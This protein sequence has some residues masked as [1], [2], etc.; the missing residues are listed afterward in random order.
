MKKKRNF[1]SIRWQILI[2]LVIATATPFFY[3]SI[4]FLHSSNQVSLLEE[5]RDKHYP[6]QANMERA[7]FT[8]KIIHS[9]M[10]DAVTTGEQE[11]LV[12]AKLLN[13]QFIEILN[14]TTYIDPNKKDSIHKIKQK[15]LTYFSNNYSLA[16]SLIN[17][18]INSVSDYLEV[19]A[20]NAKQYL[21]I[22][23]MLEDFNS[24]EMKKFSNAVDRVTDRANTIVNLGAPIG[25]IIISIIFFLGYQSVYR[26]I[27][28]INH[29]VHILCSIAKNENDMSVRIDIDGRDEMAEL[30][31]WFN[32]FMAKQEKDTI[33]ST[34]KIRQLAYMDTLT[35]LPNRRLFN[36]R[37][38]GEVEYCRRNHLSMAVMFLD[39]DNF[40]N[41][42]DQ[43][44]H[45][46]GDQLVCE[47]ARR[48]IDIVRKYDV[49]GRATDDTNKNY[50]LVSRMGGDEFNI[51]LARIVDKQSVAN[52]AGRILKE[53]SS[54]IEIQDHT[55]ET[56][57]SI[58]TA[59]YP[60]DALIA[61]ELIINADLAMYEAKR[62]GKN[63]HYFFHPTMKENT[64]Y[65]NDI[66]TSLKKVLKENGNNELF[67]HFQ[68]K[69][70]INSNVI[71]GAEALLRWKSSGFGF[72][73][74]EDFIPLAE[75]S[76]LIC[77]LDSWVLTTVFKQIQKW[78]Q[79][80]LQLVPIAINISAKQ[81]AKKNLVDFIERALSETDV[82]PKFIEL[83]ITETAALNEREIVADNIRSL[84]RIGVSV[85]IDDFGAGHASLSLLKYC[86]ID[87]LKIDRGFVSDI[88][89][90]SDN[91]II[92]GI[93]ALAKSLKIKTIAEGVET[94][95][96][97]HLLDELGC[98]MVQG[99][100]L[101]KPIPAI[102]F[103]KVLGFMN[104]SIA[105]DQPVYYLKK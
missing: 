47:V 48:L 87:A 19:G 57:V 25:L 7:L 63:T 72:V 36:F 31:F 55:I 98:D 26:V 6:V 69:F 71:V 96:Q 97:L 84:K 82:P 76:N 104:K 58:G 102:E 51:I 74:P 43:K 13:D 66:K 80:G 27:K 39:L 1:S 8:L 24:S 79:A 41:I 28:R 18:P 95:Q 99:Y 44:G 91:T 105:Q 94:K 46:V 75:K 29:M 73:P 23:N 40:K 83:E 103:E 64:K 37:L 12:E 30:A 49:V 33:K 92:Q 22:I 17:K 20:E 90:M 53:I 62:N 60:E 89:L 3:I 93:I 78:Y 9:K 42:N 50:S 70:E 11:S 52:I 34:K 38:L 100:F 15:F 59:I 68:P 21:E 54:P 4:I 61:E 16:F 35:N 81:A 88:D 85:S 32:E 65:S 2:L 67:F 45:D 101:S 77:D 86:Q 56:G 5:I 14:S 10:Q